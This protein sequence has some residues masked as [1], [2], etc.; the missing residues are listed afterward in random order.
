MQIDL[1]LFQM[2]GVALAVRYGS[3][4]FER[5]WQKNRPS[6]VETAN[7]LDEKIETK[8]GQWPVELHLIYDQAVKKI[9]S[10]IDYVANPVVFRRVERALLALINPENRAALLDEY[11]E[12]LMGKAKA[13]VS[14][15]LKTIINAEKEAVAVEAVG[16]QASI[17]LPP[18][19][20][21]T[22]DIRADVKAAV[23]ALKHE[24]PKGITTEEINA[25]I[26]A[27]RAKLK[28]FIEAKK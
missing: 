25:R 4:L 17:S 8:T 3:K 21:A 26:E 11:Y 14:E 13:A 20:L 22:R 9:V 2:A 24:E 5:I 7:G 16:A 15:E 10:G 1:G 12:I 6:F 23:V 28:A 19:F 18:E 27:S